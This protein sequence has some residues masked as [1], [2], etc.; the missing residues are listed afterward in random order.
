M[1]DTVIQG[2]IMLVTY[3]RAKTAQ[4]LGLNFSWPS[5]ARRG[6]AELTCVEVK[7]TIG[8]KVKYILGFSNL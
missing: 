6:A 8:Y 5:L 4:R 2:D 7:L 3:D 1:L